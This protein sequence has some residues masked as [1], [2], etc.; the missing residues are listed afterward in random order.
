MIHLPL[1]HSMERTWTEVQ[2]DLSTKSKAE[3]EEIVQTAAKKRNR[4]IV[5]GLVGVAIGVTVST[6]AS[7][8]DPQAPWKH[9]VGMG[10]LYTGTIYYFAQFVRTHYYGCTAELGT[11]LLEKNS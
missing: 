8:Y 2:S 1:I 9:Y 5:H 11:G 4:A 3:L 7:P 10:G 6:L